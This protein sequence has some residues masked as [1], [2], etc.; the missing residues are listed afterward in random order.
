MDDLMLDRFARQILLPQWGVEA[1]LAV[2]DKRVLIVGCGGLGSWT[3][4]FLA[5]AG[6]GH[7]TV[8]DPDVVERSNLHRQ[9]FATSAL[10]Q[11]KAQVLAQDLA[12][13]TQVQ[14]LPIAIDGAWLQQHGSDFDLWIDASDRW[15]IRMDMSAASTDQGVPWIYGSAISLS[16]Q[17]A[18]FDPTQIDQPCYHCIFGQ[19]KDPGH[20][21]EASGVLGPVVAQVSTTQSQWALAYLG[22]LAP[23]PAGRIRRWDGVLL[24]CM[25]L[26][27]RKQSDCR[28][29]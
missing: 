29:A 10:G 4:Q 16:G 22:G 21:C 24:D 26:G 1:Q 12:E 23:L 28:C 8:A 20:S 9:A 27:S 19:Q 13:F 5:R 11:P 6:V 18:A 2:A 14:G 7:L 17:V 25:E 3:A 15:D